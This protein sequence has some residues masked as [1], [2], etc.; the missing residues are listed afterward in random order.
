[1]L[2]E[3]EKI[4]C[5]QFVA[6]NDVVKGRE[7]LNIAF[8]ANLL[9]NYPN[10]DPPE[11]EEEEIIETREEKSKSEHINLSHCGWQNFCGATVYRNWMNS[12]GVSPKVKWLYTDLDNGLILFQL[13]D[14]IQP[15]IVDWKKV[16][17]KFDQIEAK[18]KPTQ[19]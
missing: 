4:G 19:S 9:N 16:V 6:A 15:G 7:K 10:M 18:A 8:T 3:A 2:D 11:V 14:F 17:K 12:L 5:K 13:M 1:M